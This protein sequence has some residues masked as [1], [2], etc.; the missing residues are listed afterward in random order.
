VRYQ[1]VSDRERFSIRCSAQKQAFFAKVDTVDALSFQDMNLSRPLL[2][3]ITAM[4][5]NNPTPVQARTIPVALMAK[6]MCACAN[7][8]SGMWTGTQ[9]FVKNVTPWRNT[10]RSHGG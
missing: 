8:G 5:Y 9:V 1:D 3:A 4:G 10:D 2:R 7:T 6:D